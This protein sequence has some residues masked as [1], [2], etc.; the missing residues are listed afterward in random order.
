MSEQQLPLR[1]GLRDSATFANFFPG[2]NAAAL[3]ALQ[4][5]AE[6]FIYLWGG[7][8]CGKSHLLQAACH[9]ETARGGV[10]AYLPLAEL[11]AA[12]ADVLEG[13]EAMSLVCVDDL[14]RIAGVR[15]WEEALFHLYNRVREAGGRLLVAAAVG[16]AALDLTLADLRSRLGWGPVF[17][18]HPLGDD[19]KLA[20]LQLRAHAR[21]LEL[22]DEVGAYLLKRS[23]RDMHALFELLERLDHASLV[24][25]RRLT[26]PFVREL[27]S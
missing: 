26:I 16:P 22:P 10:P 13:M 12:G 1:I 7:S 11:A 20:A 8:G 18:L 2:D 23:P 6:P 17:Q 24:A 4:Q 27:I 15:E 3:Y 21:G 9:A 19:G 14:E 5:A 25:Q